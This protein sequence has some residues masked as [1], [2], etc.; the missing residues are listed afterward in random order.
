VPGT[1]APSLPGV[2]TIARPLFDLVTRAFASAAH[3]ATKAG[4]APV[5]RRA[6]LG[7]GG[8]APKKKQSAQ[9]FSSSRLIAAYHMPKSGA[10][11]QDLGPREL[12]PGSKEIKNLVKIGVWQTSRL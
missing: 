9:S 7:G 2:R 11:D 10:R 8:A 1:C 5:M 4:F 12:I 3:L 6:A